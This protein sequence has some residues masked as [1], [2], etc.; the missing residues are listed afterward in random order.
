MASALA[1]RGIA[2]WSLEYRRIGDP[3]GGYPGTFDDIELALSRLDLLASRGVDVA[4]P[5]LAGHSAGGHLALWAAARHVTS[6]AGVVGLGA[7]ADLEAYAAGTSACERA[8]IDLMGGTPGEMADRYALASP[9]RLELHPDT[10][11]VH[12]RADG[13]VPTGQVTDLPV[14]DRIVLVDAGHFELIHPETRAFQDVIS[15]IEVL[16]Q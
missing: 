16:L 6:T 2:V 13:I 3:G 11:L 14:A 5:I 15:T 12:G 8:T 9:A 4:S 7:I 10:Y 1:R